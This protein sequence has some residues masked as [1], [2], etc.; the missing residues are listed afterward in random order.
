MSLTFFFV[1]CFSVLRAV[2]PEFVQRGV[3]PSL[4]VY[5]RSGGG[6][7]ADVEDVVVLLHQPHRLP[8]APFTRDGLPGQQKA[9]T[10]IDMRNEVAGFQHP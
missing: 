9:D 6:M 1:F 10:M 5:Q 4:P 8:A 2:L 7:N 3:V